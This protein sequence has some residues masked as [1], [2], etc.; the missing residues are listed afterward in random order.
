MHTVSNRTPIRTL[1]MAILTV[2]LLAGVGLGPLPAAAQTCP[3]TPSYP[4]YAPI[5]VQDISTPCTDNY[6]TYQCTINSVSLNPDPTLSN[7]VTTGSASM[8]AVNQPAFLGAYGSFTI[9]LKPT[10]ADRQLSPLQCFLIPVII[11]TTV[12]EYSMADGTFVNGTPPTNTLN[13]NFAVAIGSPA[14]SVFFADPVH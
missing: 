1:M 8:V 10:L 3:Y 13:P 4:P 11:T 9:L 6:N 14:T 5:L 7:L 2:G 12:V